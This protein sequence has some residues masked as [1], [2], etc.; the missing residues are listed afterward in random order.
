[1][2]ED[3]LPTSLS[4]DMLADHQGVQAN[5]ASGGE[6]VVVAETQ[7]P[8]AL[9]QSLAQMEKNVTRLEAE[10][11]AGTEYPDWWYSRDET[12]PRAIIAQLQAQDTD[13]AS[14][15]WY[16]SL[17]SR[18][19]TT[20]SLITGKE[21][22]NTLVGSLQGELGI[23]V[24]SKGFRSEDSRGIIHDEVLKGLV[25]HPKIHTEAEARIARE[26]ALDVL[27]E[28]YGL[29]KAT[30]ILSLKGDDYTDAVHTAT[31]TEEVLRSMQSRDQERSDTDT[32]I[33]EIQEY[34]RQWISDALMAATGIE[35]LE[36]RKYAYSASRKDITAD[37][38][39]LMQ[40]FDEFGV[41]RLRALAGFTRIY[42]PECYRVEQLERMENIMLNPGEAAADLA[43]KDV[44]ILF[45]NRAG[46]RTGSLREH[47][48]TFEPEDDT[49]A[50]TLVF[51]IE[52]LGDIYRD[53]STMNKLGIYPS[54]IVP[55]GHSDKGQFMVSNDR[56]YSPK[57]V[58]MASV[59]GRNFVQNVIDDG[60]LEAGWN[61]Y[62]MHEMRG[63]ARLVET[64]MAPSGAVNDPAEDEGRKKIIFVACDAASEID[65]KELDDAGEKHNLGKESIV[66]RLAHD[67]QEL[68]LDSAVDVYGGAAT[69]AIRLTE[70]GVAYTTPESEK[71]GAKHLPLHA[72]RVRLE[73][74]VV[75]SQEVDEVPL[76]HAS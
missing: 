38:L 73:N 61:A 67:L 53:I 36:A 30:D 33:A 59:H 8:Q 3:L 21:P 65:M 46:D 4:Q 26:N 31:R 68:V 76:R 57:H 58:T 41:E 39:K 37:V 72:T 12:N 11:I 28:A 20:R 75:T 56:D 40:R 34:R 17:Q 74:G 54:T 63:F 48:E 55:E 7:V 69:V 42:A 35:A 24:I 71:F 23:G 43:K 52:D 60:A 18:L 15:S 1:M 64:Y 5:G 2:S 49:S 62:A 70:S 44:I 51:E 14:I 6:P 13:P 29:E 16:A 50:R 32:P 27:R 66:S 25:G 22:D 45:I 47:A 19:R 10:A 9:M